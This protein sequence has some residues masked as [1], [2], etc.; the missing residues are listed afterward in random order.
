MLVLR[1]DSVRE[2]VQAGLPDDRVSGGL[3]PA[4]GLG[5]SFRNMVAEDR[6]SIG[7]PEPVRV[8]EILDRERRSLLRGGLLTDR[9]ERV[10]VPVP[11]PDRGERLFGRDRRQSARRL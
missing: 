5:R 11:P 2:L 6:R 9:D 10:E 4:D 7:R 1:C 8:E 3:E